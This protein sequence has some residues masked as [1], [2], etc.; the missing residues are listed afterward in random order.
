MFMNLNNGGDYLEIR[1]LRYFLAVAREENI[2]VAANSLFISQSALSRQIADLE[3]E[4]GVKLFQRTNKQ[5][6]LTEDGMH[7]LQRAEEIV[8]LV[9]STESEMRSGRENIIGEVRIGAGESRAFALVAKAIKKIRGKYPGIT[10]TVFSGNAVTVAEKLEHGSLD[11]GLMFNPVNTDRYDYIEIPHY[12]AVGLIVR[13]DSPLADKQVINAEDLIGLPLIVSSRISPESILTNLPEKVIN[14]LTI[15]GSYNLIYNAAIMVEHE[16]G[17]A[18]AIEGL[19]NNYGNDS[20]VFIPIEGA[21]YMST[22]FV[23]KKQ[24]IL[25]GASEVFLDELK[26]IF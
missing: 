25:S 8:E 20:L 22:V 11:F 17:A 10:F 7:F 2:T 14:K 5:T 16:I 9:K 3:N 18:L 19:I 15:A 4:L 12:D 21:D 26:N 23:W 13:K 24:H 6:L 1:T